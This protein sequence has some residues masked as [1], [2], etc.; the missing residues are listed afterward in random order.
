[1]THA[2]S[3]KTDNI[4]NTDT[5]PLCNNRMF[6]GSEHNTITPSAKWEDGDSYKNCYC[7]DD[8][9]CNNNGCC[10]IDC[11]TSHASCV[12]R[13][14]MATVFGCCCLTRNCC[15]SICIGLYDDEN[16]VHTDNENRKSW[17]MSS[18]VWLLLCSV[19]A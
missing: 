7:H 16:K 8:C 10:S 6:I 2:C 18:P 13:I 9:K 15:D 3:M 17:T 12:G 19:T 1:M 5:A 11:V 4:F 14:F